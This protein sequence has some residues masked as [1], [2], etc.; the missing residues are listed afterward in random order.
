MKG[1]L[2]RA[3]KYILKEYKQPIVKAEIVQKQ[4]TELFAD[5]VYLVTGG[6]SG[7]GYYIA[8]KL[9]SENAKVIITGR[10]QEKLEK[11]KKELGEKCDTMVADVKN[12]SDCDSILKKIF[13]KYNKLDGLISNAGISLHEWD[14]MKVTEEGFENQFQTNLKGGYFLVQSY[15]RLIKENKQQE[16]NVI[17]MSSEAGTM[18]DDLP[19]GLTKASIDSLVKALSYRYY[20][21]G[22]RVN[23]VAPGVTATEM[24]NINKEDDLYYDSNS[25]RF[26]LPE[27]VAEVVCF[28][29]SDYSKCISGEIIHTNAG[30]HIK[31]RY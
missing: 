31:R 13:K 16:G 30:N 17:F 21:E 5:K 14:F 24:T 11:A 18:C 25:G 20:K 10:N 22:I 27:E 23:A 29:L 1:Y 6:G 8:K 2:K 15:F 19:Y 12:T 9:I 28:L 7:L 26:F 4:P 3:I